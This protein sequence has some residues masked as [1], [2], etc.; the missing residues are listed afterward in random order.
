MKPGTAGAGAT[1]WQCGLDRLPADSCFPAPSGLTRTWTSLIPLRPP[2]RGVGR[3][4]PAVVPAAPGG[5]GAPMRRRGRSR[6][7]A[8]ASRLSGRVVATPISPTTCQAHAPDHRH[9]LPLPRVRRHRQRAAGG[10]PVAAQAAG[11]APDSGARGRR[12]GGG[13]GRCGAG[14]RRL[15]LVVPGRRPR[16]GGRQ[17]TCPRVPDRLSPGDGAGRGQRVRVG[18]AV[19]L[20]RRT[21][22]V[23]EAGA[24]VRAAGRGDHARDH[25]LR[26]RRADR[27]IPLDPVRLRT[28]PGGIRH[29]DVV[30]LAGER[31]PGAQQAAAIAARPHPHGAGVPR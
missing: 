17:R 9:S 1:P 18:D 12:L 25:D 4:E 11:I 8:L 14:L 13:L 2:P 21:D 7:T 30:R 31:E 26:G 5:D 10:R 19:H 23:P 28:D 16:Q 22:R 24:G 3:C 20:L 6:M 27:E 15:V 29:Q